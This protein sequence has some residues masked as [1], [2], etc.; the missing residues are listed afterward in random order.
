MR[1]FYTKEWDRDGRAKTSQKFSQATLSK[2]GG[3]SKDRVKKG[4][5]KTEELATESN[6]TKK[7]VYRVSAR[8]EETRTLRGGVFLSSHSNGTY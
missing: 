4:G 1:T 2:K 5:Q 6:P 7:T 3:E 8:H